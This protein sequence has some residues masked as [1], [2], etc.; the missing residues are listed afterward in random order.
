[1]MGFCDSGGRGETDVVL[2]TLA[3]TDLLVLCLCFIHAQHLNLGALHTTEVLEPCWLIEPIFNFCRKVGLLRL[4]EKPKPMNKTTVRGKIKVTVQTIY[5]Y[6]SNFPGV[7]NIPSLSSILFPQ[8]QVRG[9]QRRSTRS[10]VLPSCFPNST[11]ICFFKNI[12]VFIWLCW[13]LVAAHGIV[14]TCGLL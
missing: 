6:P 1:M 7:I 8:L 4:I 12:Y 11:S 2:T 10:P 14:A 9:S 13:V 3:T 5:K